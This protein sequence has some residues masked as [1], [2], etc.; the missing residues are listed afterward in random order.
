MPHCSALYH[1]SSD[2]DRSVII[3]A[4]LRLLEL[5][6]FIKSDNPTL[7]GVIAV[8][9]TQIELHYGNAAST[10]PCIKPL[11]HA[12]NTGFGAI[13][14]N[15]VAAKEASGS[16]SGNYALRSIRHPTLKKTLCNLAE[17]V[18]AQC[19]FPV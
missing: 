5:N 15:T 4:I 14:L 11:M 13:D 2:I 12:V 3:F 7:T 9:W 8:L 17:S 16:G 1:S 6:K 10:I 19:D 18:R